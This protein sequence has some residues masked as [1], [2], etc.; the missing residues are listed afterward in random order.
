MFQALSRPV[1]F[2][3]DNFT[4]SMNFRIAVTWLVAYSLPAKWDSLIDEKNWTSLRLALD[5][6]DL[7][8]A[9]GLLERLKEERIIL[10]GIIKELETKTNELQLV[11]P[12][13]QWAESD[14][15]VYLQVKLAA[16]W[17]SPGALSVEGEQVEILAKSVSFSGIGIHSGVRKQYILYLPLKHEVDPLNSK[18]NWGSLGKLMFTLKKRETGSWEQ[19]LSEEVKNSISPWWELMETFEEAERKLAKNNTSSNTTDTTK[20][21]NI[22]TSN[23]VEL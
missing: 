4:P 9:Q 6:V 1:S 21:Q 14:D 5:E 15:Q 20:N 17:S 7:E 2:S 11:A 18:W 19:L 3:T 23:K 8:I 22:S 16:R 12:A 13:V 10:N